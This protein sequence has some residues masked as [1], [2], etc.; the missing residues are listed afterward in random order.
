MVF[1][2]I[3]ALVLAGLSLLVFGERLGLPAPIAASGV[4]LVLVCGGCAVALAATTTRLPLYLGAKAGPTA[5]LALALG[6]IPVAILLPLSLRVD[7]VEGGV[8]LAGFAVGAL[9]FP[10]C[11]K[12]FWRPARDILGLSSLLVAM[13]L[14]LAALPG[15]APLVQFHTG[16]GPKAALLVILLPGFA[17]LLGGAVGVVRLAGFLAG[18]FLLMV[19]VPLGVDALST[20]LLYDAIQTG[21]RFVLEHKPDEMVTKLRLLADG[22]EKAKFGWVF[23]A[24]LALS[25]P[26]S[27]FLMQ[28][29]KHYARLAA[30]LLTVLGMGF[31]VILGVLCAQAF[32]TMLMTEIAAVSPN[33]WPPFVFDE[34]ISGWIT[35]CGIAPNDAADVVRAC[36]EGAGKAMTSAADTG[37]ILDTRL[38]APAFAMWRGWPIV[39][40]LLANMVLPFLLLAGLAMLLNHAAVRFSEI[41]LHGWLL[42]HALKTMRVSLAR[43]SVLGM[44]A[45]FGLW[46]R[47]GYTLPRAMLEIGLVAAACFCVLA[48][49]MALLAFIPGWYQRRAAHEAATRAAPAPA[50]P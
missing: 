6:S 9:V 50:T 43:L 29:E 19:V 21:M 22:G 31:I 17:V 38:A 27:T 34:R 4:F 14:L 7:L 15:S 33:L 30:S 32:Q 25:L 1:R 44:M 37:L 18:T 49:F 5:L 40:G 20:S 46:L 35:V 39:F 24:G 42:P 3:L 41:V 16:T 47:N 2:V 13:L 12:P 11:P 8:F 23:A 48:Y 10:H 36:K 45:G 28:V 26:F